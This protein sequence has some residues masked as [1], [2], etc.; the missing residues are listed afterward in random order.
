L[1]SGSSDA[2]WR[3]ALLE[4]VARE[5]ALTAHLEGEHEQANARLRAVEQYLALV[6]RVRRKNR[7]ASGSAPDPNIG[8]Q[9]SRLDE[10]Q[11]AIDRHLLRAP[12]EDTGNGTSRKAGVRGKLGMGE[13]ASVDFSQDGRDELRLEDGLEATALRDAEQLGQA[14][15][16]RLLGHCVISL[17]RARARSMWR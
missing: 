2:L 9:P 17:M 10:P 8:F 6:V 13:A 11:H 4:G 14:T 12:R 16:G 7:G 3:D 15:S 1:V 5:K